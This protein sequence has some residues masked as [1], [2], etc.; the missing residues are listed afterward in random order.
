LVAFSIVHAC[1]AFA[2]VVPPKVYDHPAPNAWI[3]ERT[4][5]QIREIC[6]RYSPW[7]EVAA[8]ALY[9]GRNKRCIILWPRG[10]KRAGLLWRHE[11]AHCNGWP[12]YHPAR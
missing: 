12:A 9:A 2:G 8:C 11:H 1:P 6:D 3:I 5:A 7:K 4:P 10:R